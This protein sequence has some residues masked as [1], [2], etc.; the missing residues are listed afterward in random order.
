MRA[1][2]TNNP[3]QDVTSTSLICGAAGSKSQTVVSANA[4]DKIGAWF[5]HVIGGPQGANDPDN[6]IAPSHHGPVIAYM[7]KVDNAASSS[8]TG[9]QWFKIGQDTYDTSSKKWGVGE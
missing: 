7:A 3:V 6:P 5:Q 2:S 9:L 8:Q 1:P 4:G